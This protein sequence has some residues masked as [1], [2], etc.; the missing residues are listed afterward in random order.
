MTPELESGIVTL[1]V[2]FIRRN[3]DRPLQ[4]DPR[5][6][7]QRQTPARPERARVK[8]CGDETRS[9]HRS[10]T[11]ATVDEP[12]SPLRSTAHRVL[13][14][15]PESTEGSDRRP[16]NICVSA[17][18]LTLT[19]RSPGSGRTWPSSAPVAAHR[20]KKRITVPRAL[21]EGP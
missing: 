3:L 11:P 8:E 20:R 7:A 5:L 15:M 4:E 6:A 16:Q 17:A 21:G 10:L 12:R 1:G 13:I 9:L 18:A 19:A 2:V 14:S